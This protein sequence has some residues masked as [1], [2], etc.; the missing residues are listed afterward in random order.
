MKRHQLHSALRIVACSDTCDHAPGRDEFPVR[1]VDIRLVDLVSKEE[2]PLLLAKPHKGLKVFLR[3]DLPC[4]VSRID[5]HQGTRVQAVCSRRS[6]RLLK[7]RNRQAPAA[8]LIHVVLDQFPTQQRNERGVDRV[9]RDRD[10]HSIARASDKRCQDALDSSTCS[11]QE[12]DVVRIARGSTVPCLDE[13]ADVTTH[14]RNALRV[15]VGT[16][17]TCGFGELRG[18]IDDITGKAAPPALAPLEEAGGVHQ[19]QDLA[20]KGD[21]RLPHSLRIPDVASQQLREVVGTR[22]TASG[23]GF[24][25]QGYLLRSLGHLSSD[26]I[27]HVQQLFIHVVET[28][29]SACQCRS[30]RIMLRLTLEDER[31]ATKHASQHKW[32]K[33]TPA[34]SLWNLG[35]RSG[36]LHRACPGHGSY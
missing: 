19:A 7:L 20:V 25:L 2:E 29:C 15:R 34:R 13:V 12:E 3:K 16:C 10:H 35:P 18:P 8:R 28:Q 14:E 9:L 17:A 36:I 31:H 26:C 6:D 32:Q 27:L 1:R 23:C 11:V 21:G 24:E 30:R 33:P 4:R 5:H 22:R